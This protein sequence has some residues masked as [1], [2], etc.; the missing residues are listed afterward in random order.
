M[1]R[2]STDSN[3]R[4][5]CIW[6]HKDLSTLSSPEQNRK[7]WRLKK[8][9][10]TFEEQLSEKTAYRNLVVKTLK[11]E[12][13]KMCVQLEELAKQSQEKA[14]EENRLSADLRKANG[15]HQISN[16]RCRV[17]KGSAGSQNGA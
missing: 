8:P 1:H 12:I 10:K 11:I 2:R 13:Y 3:D 9:L 15:Y 6:N 5:R 16:R 14:M 7:R 17:C 4:A